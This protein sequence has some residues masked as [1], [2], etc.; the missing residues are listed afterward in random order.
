[1]SHS[2][3][4]SLNFPFQKQELLF[5][6]RIIPKKILGFRRIRNTLINPNSDFEIFK[7]EFLSNFDPG[8]SLGVFREAPPTLIL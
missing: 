3:H 6:N 4:F 7:I 8:A 1:M 5:C 2:V